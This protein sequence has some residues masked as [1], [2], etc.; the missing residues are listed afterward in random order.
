M[1]QRQTL[2]RHFCW[3]AGLVSARARFCGARSLTV[4]AMPKISP[5]CNREVVDFELPYIGFGKLLLLFAFDGGF[6]AC[7]LPAR[8]DS[9]LNNDMEMSQTLQCH[10]CANLT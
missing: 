9:L 4:M 5:Q 3:R 8:C 7:C 10:S 1:E 6:A 2:Q